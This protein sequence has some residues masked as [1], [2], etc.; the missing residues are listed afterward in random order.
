MEKKLSEE[1]LKE[2]RDLNANYAKLLS[3]LGEVE[4]ILSDLEGQ[5]E[6]VKAEK[7]GLF[8]DYK[9]LKEK[10]DSMYTKLSEEY[11]SG[12]IDLETGIIHSA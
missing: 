9:T 7:Q 8:S 2:L 12:K 5:V 1:H 11:G 4:L 6:R 10:S 3:S